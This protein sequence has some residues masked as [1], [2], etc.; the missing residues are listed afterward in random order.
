MIRATVQQLEQR[1]NERGYALEEVYGC[2]VRQNT[3]G[4][5]MVDVKHEKYPSKT[6]ARTPIV[7]TKPSPQKKEEKYLGDYIAD[8]LESVGITKERVS[9]VM[10]G[11]CGCSKRQRKL[12][13]LHQNFNK[14]IRGK[15]GN[16][17]GN[18]KS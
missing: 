15:D 9:K 3:D 1:A 4:T 6:K 7:V 13:R 18:K 12:N 14:F 5:I 17:L 10:G 16:K 11:D 8:G 2:I